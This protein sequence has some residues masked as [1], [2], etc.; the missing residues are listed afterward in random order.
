MA[1]VVMSVSQQSASLV[2]LKSPRLDKTSILLCTCNGPILNR[3][4]SKKS[5]RKQLCIL[6]SKVASQQLVLPAEQY[7][8]FCGGVYGSNNSLLSS[9]SSSAILWSQGE[10]R[11]SFFGH[12][13]CER[14]HGHIEIS[15]STLLPPHLKLPKIIRLSKCL[16]ALQENIVNQNTTRSGIQIT[17]L[18][19]TVY[20]TPI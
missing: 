16:V 7:Q 4:V 5:K 8:Q 15:I 19:T 1:R 20:K 17:L 14:P 11:L 2:L 6:T 13:P 10:S 18:L 3:P 9:S 12:Q